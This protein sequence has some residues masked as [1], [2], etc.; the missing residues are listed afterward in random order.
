MLMKKVTLLVAMMALLF[1]AAAKPV[2]PSILGRIAGTFFPGQTFTYT[3]YADGV[4]LF[5]PVEKPGFV[6][7]AAD[8]C[9]RPVL[10]FSRTGSFVTD[11]M[12]KHVSQWIDGYAHE[13]ASLTAAEAVPSAA[14]TA[15]W[16]FFLEATA[17]SMGDSIGPLLT[18]RW[19]QAPYYN[20]LCP[21]DVYDSMY[22]YAGCTATATAQIM[23]YWNHPEVGWG[24]YAY[25]HPLY[26]LQSAS[27][28]TTHYNWSMMPDAINY[29][30]DSAEIMAVAELMYHVGVAV[31]MNYGTSG[32]GSAVNAYGNSSR[33][34]AENA[35]KTYFRYSPMLQGVFKTEFT[36]YQ[37]DSIMSIEIEAGRP[38]LYAG[39]DSSAG[40]AFVLDG[41]S[42][43]NVY[44]DSTDTV[45]TP[46][47]F[48]HVNWGWG[49]GYDGYFTLDELSP[50]AGGAGGNATYTFNMNNS[51][52]IGI[53]PATAVSDSVVTINVAAD[54][55]SHGSVMGSGTYRIGYD[56]V[57]IWARA[58]DG[59]RFV[60]WKSGSLQNPISFNAFGD[61]TDTA[62]FESIAGDT[63]GYCQDGLVTSWSDD[64]TSTTE[65]G[66][67]IPATMRGV[68]RQMTA[69]QF[70]PYDFGIYT[71]T[72]YIGPDINTATAVH[73]QTLSIMSNAEI[74]QW[75]TYELSSPVILPEG[76]ALWVTMRNTGSD[77]PATS[78]RYTGNSDG[79]WYKLPQGWAQF[80]VEDIFYATW[81]LRAVLEPRHFTID[82]SPNDINACT[83]FGGGE[84]NGGDE[85]TIG[86]VVFNDNCHFVRWSDGSPYNPYT[87][88]ATSDTVMI[89]YCDCDLGIDDIDADGLT[90]SVEGR[91]IYV[92]T[93]STVAIYDIQG[94]LLS[95]SRRFEAP[96]AGVYVIRASGA[97]RKVVVL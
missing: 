97:T 55:V 18:T 68:G 48:F 20:L 56:V 86:A 92:E 46:T 74:R 30:S 1:V 45:G 33:P 69:V 58:A 79:S 35:L 81:M 40:H 2:E 60:R 11:A 84:Y 47:R 32:S 71:L 67:R 12:P 90:V 61:L 93:T 5:T 14:V 77:F 34:S 28:G 29:L 65:W 82:V 88:V 16:N 13:I 63:L 26:G 75:N 8:D 25:Q 19:N 36:D 43:F 78:S 3:V 27:F 24:S 70:F 39:Y 72:I 91:Q 85:V 41:Y 95:R 38:V 31:Q 4:Y 83:T 49:G 50:G 89:A 73:T 23:K 37:W 7:L 10:A 21:Y 22:T 94:R 59:Y 80:D 51:A 66:I 44:A 9:V 42:T 54:N 96:A 52:V 53:M 6:L 17:K 57:R 15:E 64:Y 87:F 76:A 62:I